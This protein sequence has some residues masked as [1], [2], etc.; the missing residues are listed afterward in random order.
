M[1]PLKRSSAVVTHDPEI[2][3]LAAFLD[4]LVDNRAVIST[5]TALFVVVGV[6]YAWLAPPV[7]E[8]AITLQVEEDR[9]T[10]TPKGM[11]GDMSQLV[12]IKSPAEAEMQI[13]GSRFVLSRSVDALRLYISAQPRRFPLIGS[14]IARYSDGL[15]R[16]GLFGIGGYAWGSESI[17]VAAFDVPPHDEGRRYTLR[18]LSGGRYALQGDG[19]D[20]EAIG[21][22]GVGERFATRAGPVLLRVERM[23]AREGIVFELTRDSFQQTV[24]QLRKALIIAEKGKQSGVI[25]A[26]LQH[27]DPELLSATLNEISR[28]YLRQNI[29]RKAAQA[30][31]SL[32]FLVDQQPEMKHQLEESEN[33]YN[34]YRNTHSIIDLGEEGKVIL[35]RSADVES[36]LLQLRQKREELLMRYMPSHP[37][38]IAIDAQIAE[39]AKVAGELA[40]RVKQMPLSEQSTLRLERDVRVNTNLYVSL[41]NNIEQ[42]KL[43]KAS[44]IGNVRLIDRAEVPQIPVKPRKLMVVGLAALMGLFAGVG[45]AFIRDALLRGVTDVTA[46]ESHSG[47]SVYATIPYSKQQEALAR[48]MA[49]KTKEEDLMLATRY[50]LDP[51][52]ESL[53]SLRTALQFAMLEARNNVVL[54]TGPSPGIGKSFVSAN[55]AA[56]LAASGKHVL[57]IDGDLRAGHLD[58]YFGQSNGV[59]L[60]DAIAG[61]VACQDVVRESVRPNLDFVPTGTAALNPAELLLSDRWLELVNTVSA[62][63]DIVLID[64][65]PVLPVSDAGIMAP[66]AGTVFLLARFAQTRVGEITESVKRL[67]QGGSR[68][69]G[70]LFNGV[71]PRR[72]SYAYGGKYGRYRYAAYRNDRTRAENQVR[73]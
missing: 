72:Y 16:P 36:R 58:R 69:S 1:A 17:N 30:E 65:A 20:G 24:T 51:A 32:D 66:V 54:L 34:A 68:V 27:N 29:E 8:S 12:E 21:H 60:S 11:L 56:V 57:L 39:A 44:K 64:A 62:R 31:R 4:M 71:A 5:V 6:F 45:I 3:G 14:S 55:L 13:L 53:R 40:G 10:G 22:V 70:L 7:Y 9:D 67:A 48:K 33:R 49:V 26:T 38:V 28:Q 46:L 15:S 23:D 59:G 35:Q 42:L 25:E 47:L 43:L 73:Q 19:I 37:G 2:I 52:I 61:A 50:P 41:L 63:Y 18:V